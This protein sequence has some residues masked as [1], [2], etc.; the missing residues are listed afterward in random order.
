MSKEWD[1]FSGFHALRV[2]YLTFHCEYQS[3]LCC[4]GEVQVADS[5]ALQL[6]RAKDIPLIL[7]TPGPALPQVS[8][9]AG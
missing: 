3:L 2:N 6:A 5:Q 9:F 8:G 7:M 4:P 1:Q